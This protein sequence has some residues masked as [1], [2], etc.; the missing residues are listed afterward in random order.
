MFGYIKPLEGELK[1]REL[2]D[3]RSIYCG[4][5]NTLGNRYGIFSRNIL[6]YDFTFL[7]LLI[8]S[9]SESEEVERR[10]MRCIAHPTRKRC[11]RCADRSFETAADISVIFTFYKLKDDAKDEGIFKRLIARFFIKALKR[12]HKKAAS[13]MPECEETVK[14]NFENLCVMEREKTASIDKTADAFAN[15][16]SSAINGSGK[17]ERAARNILYHVGRWIYIIDAIDDFEKDMQAGAYN[18][19]ACRWNIDAG[20]IPEDVKRELDLTLTQSVAAAMSALELMD[21]ARDED[22]IRNILS[23]GLPHTA[24]RILNGD[25]GKKEKR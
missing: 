8:G 25:D 6:N 24:K 16:L 23:L 11:V 2:E 21:I 17:N 13:L 19:I 12:A 20:A 9:Y 4:L 22:L 7:A 3:F 1:V 18:P 14:N 5:C 10:D 15:M